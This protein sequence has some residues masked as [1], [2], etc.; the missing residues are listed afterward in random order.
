MDTGKNI[1]EK[2]SRLPQ[3][4][5]VY[6]MKD[7]QGEVIYVGK[8]KK[9]K[10]RVSSYFRQKVDRPKTELLVSKIVDFEWIVTDS[11]TEA[12]VLESNLIKEYRPQYNIRLIDDKHYP[13]IKITLEEDFPRVVVV[14]RRGS[15]KA[16]YFGPYTSATSMH[17]AIRT[18][19]S[20]FALRTCSKQ[21]FNNRKRPCLNYQIKKCSGPC[22]AYISQEDY[23][24]RIDD[25]ILLLEGNSSELLES[26]KK[27]MQEAAQ[28]LAY[29][30][31]AILRNQIYAL[32]SIAEKQKVIMENHDDQD[33]VALHVGEE[34]SLVQIFFIR[35]GK[36]ITRETFELDNTKDQTD[37]EIMGAFIK[38][39]YKQ[40]NDLPGKI[41]VSVLPDEEEILLEWLAQ[42]RGKRVVIHWPQRGASRRLIDMVAENARLTYQ[43]I[44][45]QQKKRVLS[46]K[47][48]GDLSKTLGLT[49]PAHR[50]ECFDVSNISG[51]NTVASMAVFIDGKPDVSRYRRFTIRS[52]D[53]PNDYASMEEVISRR[54]AGA[55]KH[56]E[57]FE[58]L[59]DLVIIDGGKGQLSSARKIMKA[60]GFASIPTFG[61]AEKE[62]LLFSEGSPLPL[63]LPKDSEAL[64][65][66][67][68]IRDEAHRFAISF[69]RDKRHK[70]AFTSVLDSVPGIGPKR[71]KVLLQT[72][73]SVK[74]VQRAKPEDIAKALHLK[75]EKAQ[76][77][78]E[79]LG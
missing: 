7:H 34:R 40:V 78:K 76:E 41:L 21:K 10:P 63:V 2:L 69:H 18:I 39:Y 12:L 33:V 67:Q 23:G 62:E 74:G 9:L 43:E 53:G 55:K 35:S 49:E 46:A 51:T 65:L 52:V 45:L 47:A 29:E 54:F 64:Y 15:D 3:S 16:R 27:Q 70:Q 14:R 60:Q 22:M 13:Y 72:F 37:G 48:L 17:E 19:R 42:R 73:G 11:E 50:I 32:E 56:K 25:V 5:G 77:I 28:S 71:K 38:Q 1:R 59:P 4:P 24:K 31:A 44:G 79:F 61:L 20:V 68:R 36:M 57:G 30:Q 58:H 66:V 8:A 75:L 26:L 6:L